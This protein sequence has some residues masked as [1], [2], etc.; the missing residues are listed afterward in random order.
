VNEGA[1][2]PVADRAEVTDVVRRLAGDPAAEVLAWEAAPIAHVGIIDTTGGLHRVAGTARTQA[3]E[4]E[5]TCVLKVVGRSAHDE[6][7]EPA[8]WCYW[9]REAAFYG[10]E[11]ATAL[12]GPLRAPRP[13]GVVEREDEAHVWMEDVAATSRPWDM[14]DF[15]RAARAAGVSAGAFLTG[16]PLPAEPWLAH[17]FLRGLIG[18]GG[19]WAAMMHRDTGAA[20]R[21]PFAQRFHAGT[22]ERVL[23]LWAD[24]DR[25]FAA[26]DAAPQ[27]L[28]HGDYH[29]RNIMLPPEGD[30][31]VAVDWGFCGPAPVGADL[32]DL[33]CG[34]AWFCDIEV[35]EIAAIEHAA[36]D[37]YQDGLRSAGWDGDPR[38]VRFGY[39]AQVACRMAACLPGWA[40][41]MLGAEVAP[42]S[43]ILFRHP[44]EH[45]LTAW[46]ALE[47]V[48]LRLAD[49]ARELAAELGLAA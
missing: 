38:V 31:V 2:A 3:G 32:G 22:R 14:E 36:Q 27:V 1:A 29:P 30:D 39:A 48:G 8:S 9:R 20:W 16:R 15:R 12:P 37:A 45:I 25:L 5:W 17:R 34:A 18:D 28:G 11:L 43:E 49:E 6:C 21:L 44:A 10:S 33:V 13:Y 24:R 19:F 47:E 4:R 26:L 40:A 23:A 42:S 35:D 7:R 46:V 41:E